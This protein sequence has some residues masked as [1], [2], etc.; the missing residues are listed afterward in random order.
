MSKRSMRKAIKTIIV[1][2]LIGFS[3]YFGYLTCVEVKPLIVSDARK[4]AVKE[5]AVEEV[6]GEKENDPYMR[7]ID[8]DALKKINSDIIGWLYIPETSID[9][10]IL[11]GE[12]DTEYLSK[13]VDGQYNPL[14]TIFTYADAS[15]TLTDA[16]TIL[17]AHNML[18]Y[19]MFGELKRY[20]DKDFRGKHEKIYIYTEKKTMVLQVFSVFTCLD[21]EKVF[22]HK[23]ELS[24][25]RYKDMLIELNKRNQCSD[26]KTAIDAGK[27][28]YS[29]VTCYGGYQTSERLMVNAMAIREKYLLESK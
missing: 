3:V 22:G 25:D 26:L 15:E 18:Q 13:D 19:Q 5:I 17:F 21:S 2:V 8:F 9:Y 1:F 12:S 14:G 24:T 11:K 6:K 23:M 20:L 16:R 28:T 10:P 29:L 27:Q 7:C 4:K